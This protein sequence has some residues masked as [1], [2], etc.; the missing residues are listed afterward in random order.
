MEEWRISPGISNYHFTLLGDLVRRRCK[1][2]PTTVELEH[3][4]PVDP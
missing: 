1:N 3:I 4:D 2:V